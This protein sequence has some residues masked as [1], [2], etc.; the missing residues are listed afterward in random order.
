M[1]SLKA[2]IFDMDGVLTE[3]SRQ[4]FIAWK[5]LAK[6][7]GYELKDEVNEQLKGISRLE[8]LDI[9]LSAGSLAEQFSEAEKLALA[10]KKNLIYQ[11]L[12]KTFTKEN[13]AKGALELL[14][15]LRENNIK[16]GLASV[17][18]NAAFLL[19]AMEIQG[20]F[21]AIAD[22]GEVRNGKP[23][24]DIFLLAAKKL[25]IEPQGCVGIEDAFA[26][27][28]SIHSAGMKSIGIG[29]KEE[30]YNCE[31]V[32]PNLEAVNIVLLKQVFL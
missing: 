10:E 31:V 8:S 2:V 20:F 25:G 28:Q 23:A 22:P 12:I 9:V 4:H 19:E 18:K 6:D 13:L 21:D 7:L 1:S 29:T 5:L 32:V 24:P 17:S 26:G 14:Q 16:I 30:L 15:S 11:D 27:I 3:T